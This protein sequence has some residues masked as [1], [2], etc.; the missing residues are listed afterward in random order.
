[1]QI[2]EKTLKNSLGNVKS[3]LQGQQACPWKKSQSGASSRFPDVNNH[4]GIS[5]P[6]FFSNKALFITSKL[7]KFK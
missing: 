2:Y 5:I 4:L 6:E 7:L 1:M 3:G